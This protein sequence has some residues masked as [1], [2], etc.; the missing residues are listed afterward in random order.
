MRNWI[1]TLV[2][3]VL[4]ASAVGLHAQPGNG[5]PRV[6]EKKWECPIYSTLKHA[7][8]YV[9]QALSSWFDSPREKSNC[10]Q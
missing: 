7:H 10:A 1:R 3:V 5:V 8:D 9:F 2:A 6:E 4:L